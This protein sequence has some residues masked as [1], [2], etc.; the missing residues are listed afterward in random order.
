[1]QVRDECSHCG[2]ERRAVISVVAVN[3]S[4]AQEDMIAQA[5]VKIAPCPGC[6]QRDLKVIRHWRLAI[7]RRSLSPLLTGL[8]AAFLLARLTAATLVVAVSTSRVVVATALTATLLFF[9]GRAQTR[10]RRFIALAQNVTWVAAPRFGQSGQLAGKVCADCGEGIVMETEG[11]F[12]NSCHRPVHRISCSERHSALE[13]PVGPAA[14]Y[15]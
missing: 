15:R 8:C 10:M 9:A 6:G 5:L 14:P 2:A 13:H 11:E 3:A 12:C 4:L 1:M 7:A